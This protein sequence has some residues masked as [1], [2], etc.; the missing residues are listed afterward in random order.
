MTSAKEASQ[1][2]DWDECVDNANRVL[3]NEPAADNIRFHA[4]DR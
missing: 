1:A 4:Y 3:K 2:E